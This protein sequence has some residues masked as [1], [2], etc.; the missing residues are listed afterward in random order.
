V[1]LIKNPV[2]SDRSKHIEVKYHLVRE[3]AEQGKIQVKQV[4]TGDQLGDI[5]TKALDRVKFQEMRTRR[6]LGINLE[7]VSVCVFAYCIAFMCVG[8]STTDPACRAVALRACVIAEELVLRA[9]VFWA[10]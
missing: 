1:A 4:S 7:V 10:R 5:L 9:S 2:L 3:S 6:V 8:G